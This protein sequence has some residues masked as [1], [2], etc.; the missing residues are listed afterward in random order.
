MRT[1]QHFVIDSVMDPRRFLR[2]LEDARDA[3]GDL[4]RNR[5]ARTIVWRETKKKVRRTTQDIR[6]NWRRAL[7]R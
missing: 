5:P 1:P 7:G 6:E 2:D 4:V 3:A